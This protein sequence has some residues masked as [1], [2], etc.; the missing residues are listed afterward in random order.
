M[1]PDPKATPLPAPIIDPHFRVRRD[2]VDTSGTITLRHNSRLHHLALGRRHR[3]ERVL[4]L[5]RDLEVR[6]LTEHGELLR[7]LTL[8]PARDYQRMAK[9]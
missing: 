3:G 8:D 5:V 9:P 2:R 6:V 4:V 7:Q 1:R